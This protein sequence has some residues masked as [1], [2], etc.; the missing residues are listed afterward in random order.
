VTACREGY[1]GKYAWMA[2]IISAVRIRSEGM[3]LAIQL[4]G[5]DV[6]A[7]QHGNDIAER[8]AAD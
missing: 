3:G 7:S 1:R 5:N 4:R 2:S 6:Q 8:M